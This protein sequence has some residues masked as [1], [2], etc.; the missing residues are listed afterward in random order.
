MKQ[1]ILMNALQKQQ[2]E[3][4]QIKEILANTKFAK[5]NN[6]QYQNLFWKDNIFE[7]IKTTF[8]HVFLVTFW[9]INYETIG[10]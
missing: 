1:K 5:I 3:Q 9:P 4:N 2:S 10:Y 7:E 6:T 8:F